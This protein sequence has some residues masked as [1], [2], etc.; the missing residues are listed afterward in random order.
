MEA[1]AASEE[2]TLKTFSKCLWELKWVAWEDIL[3]W[4]VEG[5]GEWEEGILALPLGSA[6][7]KSVNNVNF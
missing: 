7:N 2:W 1:W 6:D 4:D 5:L 3:A